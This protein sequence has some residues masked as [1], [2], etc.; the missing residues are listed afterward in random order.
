MVQCFNNMENNISYVDFLNIY[1]NKC[2]H[3][4]WFLGAG[5]SVAAGVPSAYDLITQFKLN[6]FCKNTGANQK[7]FQD[8]SNPTVRQTLE[9]YFIVNN[10]IPNEDEN[11]YAY[12]FEKAY[13]TEDIRRKIIE[14]AVVNRQPSYGQ[15]ILASLM[16][17]MACR[18]VWTT[19]F[20]KLIENS[21]FKLYNSNN[22]LVVSTLESTNLARDAINEER[23]PLLVKLHGDFQSTKIKNVNDEL[24]NQDAEYKKLL[25]EQCKR[26]GLV[27][28]GYSG[29]DSSIMEVLTEALDN[30]NGF[31][32]GLYWLLRIG[33]K[34]NDKLTKLIEQA[35]KLK[36]NAQ[37]IRMQ[38][39][40]ETMSDI[41]KQFENIPDDI[42]AFL[43]AKMP[44]ATF[45]PPTEKGNNFP[46]IRLNAV[47]IIKYPLECKLVDCEIGGNKEIR[48]AIETTNSN[49]V[50]IRKKIGVL[51][52][53]EDREIQK[54]F[55]KN[56]IKSI[57]R[58]E[59]ARD[60]LKDGKQELNLLYQLLV[61]CFE[62]NVP[63]VGKY[64]HN[65]YFL[66]IDKTKLQSQVFAQWYI[67]QKPFS[68]YYYG[69]IPYTNINWSQAIKIHLEFRY[70]K[71]WLIMEPTIWI[72]SIPFNDEELYNKIKI[73]INN[74]LSTRFNLASNQI[75]NAWI[76]FLIG[77]NKNKSLNLFESHNEIEI[78][79]AFIINGTTAYCK[80][81]N[82]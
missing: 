45:P 5:T 78:S 51:A 52:F 79:P 72:D 59:L 33:E 10:L 46:A 35:K 58:Y 82:K 64:K 40:D 80:G 66:I 48:N 27:V 36:I 62:N 71:L 23:W 34:P 61:K 53:G 30:G 11:D 22:N 32:H 47:P 13:P 73:F 74:K 49:I 76:E 70:N 3:L 38:N 24:K 2:Q 39:F 19:N 54:A 9:D 8:L 12:Y 63:V 81:I 20:D 14:D 16:K 44:K 21:A 1:K 77:K 55:N 75:L 65:A 67:G 18:I 15:E 43:N 4:M 68:D 31:P 17:L 29:R 28:I 56:N 69:N 50:A 6:I 37:I 26:Y 25:V 41:I 7:L 42:K 57:E 60:I